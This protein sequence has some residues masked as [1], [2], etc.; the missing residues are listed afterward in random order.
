MIKASPRTKLF[1][2]KA[3]PGDDAF[4]L[5]LATRLEA[6]GYEVFADILDLDAGWLA[7]EDHRQFTRQG[8]QNALVLQ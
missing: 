1:I 3:T 8:R 5:W 4:A 7:Q 2:S 6:E